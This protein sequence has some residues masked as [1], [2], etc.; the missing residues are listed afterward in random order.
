MSKRW[1]RIHLERWEVE[2]L[3][4]VPAVY[5]IHDWN[6]AIYVGSTKNLRSRALNHIASFGDAT[7]LTFSFS[8]TTRAGDWLTREYRI[9]RRLRP[10]MNKQ[11][12]GTSP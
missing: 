12:M 7:G 10:A 9:I 8:V 11:H 1:D 4:T 2:M 3:P 5:V 6:R